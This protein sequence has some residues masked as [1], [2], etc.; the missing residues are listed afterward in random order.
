MPCDDNMDGG[1]GVGVASATSSSD[2][3]SARPTVTSKMALTLPDPGPQT[4]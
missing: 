2:F 4:L 1:I 3:V